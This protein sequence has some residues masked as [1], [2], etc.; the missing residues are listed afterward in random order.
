MTDRTLNHDHRSQVTFSAPPN[1]NHVSLT[2]LFSHFET[3]SHH[4]FQ[5]SHAP[6]L[7]LTWWP[8]LIF[9]WK[10]RGRWGEPQVLLS[11]L[12]AESVW[13]VLSTMILPACIWDN[14]P[15]FVPW[16]W[17]AGTP[18]L[19]PDGLKNGESG[20]YTQ[21]SPYPANNFFLCAYSNSG[22]SIRLSPS[23]QVVKINVGYPAYTGMP[24]PRSNNID[25]P[26][27]TRH[28]DLHSFLFREIGHWNI[29]QNSM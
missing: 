29:H 21:H 28:A 19:I 20:C 3:I 24:H 22:G 1:S 17:R 27:P 4:L 12:P 10:N 9:H 8:H 11:Y 23:L 18:G 16:Y 15:L 2:N 5:I 25:L 6:R 26:K 13:L 7:S 14:P